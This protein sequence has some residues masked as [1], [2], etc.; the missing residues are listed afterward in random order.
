LALPEHAKPAWFVAPATGEVFEGKDD[1]YQYLQGWRL[2][3]G[4]GVVQGRVW[5]DG[6]PCWEFKCKLHDTRT[7]NIRGL[8]LRKLKDKES[9]MVT[10]S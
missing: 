10:N 3:E 2:F 8:E 7:L 9:K 6:T 4:F 1:R 5:K